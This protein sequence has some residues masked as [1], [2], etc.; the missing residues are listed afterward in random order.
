MLIEYEHD[1]ARYGPVL[2]AEE[3]AISVV[4]LSEFLHGAHRAPGRQRQQRFA[5]VEHLLS[6]FAAL[7]ITES[8]ART[9]ARVWAELEASG[10]TIGAHDLWIAAT[11]LTHDLGVATLDSSFARVP[12]LRVVTP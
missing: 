11:A 12:G 5:R 6:R 2:A 4:T 1:R 9:H 10:S 3:A 7:P 8:V